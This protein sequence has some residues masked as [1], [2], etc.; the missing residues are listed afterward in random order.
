MLACSFCLRHDSGGHGRNVTCTVNHVEKYDEL[1]AS[2]AGF[3]KQLPV[4]GVPA[5]GILLRVYEEAFFGGN[6]SQRF[7]RC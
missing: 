6:S 5:T 3:Q 1:Y 2:Q 7:P 4:L